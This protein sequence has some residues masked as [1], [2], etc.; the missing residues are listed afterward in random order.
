VRARRKAAAEVITMWA[1]SYVEF[2]DVSKT[3][4]GRAL[5]V[6]DLNCV[7]RQGEFLTFLGPS[8]SGKTTALMMLAGFETPTSGDIMLDGTVAR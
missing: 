8:G 5:A 1:S 3:Y 6:K 7:V 4:D 2:R